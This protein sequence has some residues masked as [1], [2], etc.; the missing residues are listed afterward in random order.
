MIEIR[1]YNRDSDYRL[2][3]EFIL[4]SRNGPFILLRNYVDYHADRFE[5]YSLIAERDGK[6]VALL[7]A[8]ID[9]ETLYSHRGLTYGGWI[10]GVK[11]VGAKIMLEI[12]G[13]MRAYLTGVGITTLQYKAIP[14]IYHKYPAE[15]DLYALFRNKATIVVSSV[16]AVV[17]MNNRQPFNENARRAVKYAIAS[18]VS[19]KE[20]DDYVSFWE[21]LTE[22]LN[23][24]YGAIPVHSLSEITM[25]REYFPNNIR[26]FAAYQ[27]EKMLA[28]VVTYV[29]NQVCHTQYISA[30]ELGRELKVLPMIFSYL[31]D[32]IFADV[33]YFDF[34]TSNENNGSYLNE[35]LIQQKEGMGARSI[36]YN[37]YQIKL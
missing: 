36:I 3:D 24:R 11:S 20:C 17:D 27:G 34:G 30:S 1:R 33:R 28:G 23:N 25:L 5:D 2:W 9:G 31:M 4:T 16:A 26:L 18:G 8:N 32:S 37:T 35:G 12:F 29:T 6:V 15:E 21:I 7:P 13:A 10:T 22:N 19:V 14:H